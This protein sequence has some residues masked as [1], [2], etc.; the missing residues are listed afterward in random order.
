MVSDIQY[1]DV[2]QGSP[3]WLAAR[4]GIPTASQFQTILAAGKGRETYLWKLAGERMCGEVSEGYTNADM[5]RGKRMEPLIRADYEFRSGNEVTRIGFIRNGKTGASTDGLVGKDGIV[6]F[7]STE[8]HLLIPLVKAKKVFPPKHYAQCQG[9]L[10]VSGRKWCDLMIYWHPR[11]PRLLVRTERDERF[12]S[13]L[14][15]AIDVF[16]L[17]LRRLVKEL[18]AM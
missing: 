5:E 13:E 17:E 4:L 18:E 12:I 1:L 11:M 14:R 3:E 2:E 9:G 16:D 8:P 15:D 10:M 7:K 6:E